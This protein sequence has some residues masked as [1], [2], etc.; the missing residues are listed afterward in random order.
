MGRGSR[1]G[2]GTRTSRGAAAAQGRR[3]APPAPAATTIAA[4]EAT[5]HPAPHAEATSS[6]RPAATTTPARPAAPTV[7]TA[8]ARAATPAATTTPARAAETAQAPRTEGAATPRG[9]GLAW[10]T[11]AAVALFWCA[12]ALPYV[13]EGYERFRLVKP[14]AVAGVKAPW[15]AAP[16]VVPRDDLE[17][18]EVVDHGLRPPELRVPPPPTDL[19]PPAP[20]TSGAGPNADVL[21]A[22]LGL[23][24]GSIEDESGAMAHFYSALARTAA[25]EPGAVTRIVHFGDSPVTGDLITGGARRRLQTLYGD[26]GHGWVLPQ[27]PWEWYNHVG[28]ELDGAGWKMNSPLFGSARDGRCGLAG[29]AFR[30]ARGASTKIATPRGG[31]NGAVSDFVVH[32]LGRPGGGTLLASVDGAP[33]IEIGTAAASPAPATREIHVPDGP[34]SLSLSPKGDGEVALYGVALEREE[35][36]VVYDSIGA[37]GATAHFLSLL[38][39][40]DWQAELRLR[41]PDLVVLNYGT[42]ESG[43]VGLS[44]DKLRR[45]V[46]AL[47]ARV[48]AAAPNASVL[49]MAPMDRGARGEDGSLTT[50][51]TIPQIVEAER[52]AAKAAGAA[53]FDTYSAM[54]G[55]GTMARW[56]ERENRLVSGDLTHPTG[57]GADIVSR[58][59]VDALEAGRR[60][61]GAQGPIG[62]A[63]GLG[64]KA[65]AAPRRA[66]APPKPRGDADVAAAAETDAPKSVAAEAEKETP[67]S[68]AAEAP[69]GGAAETEKETPRSGAAEA[70]SG[71]AAEAEKGTPRPDEAAAPK[72]RKADRSAAQQ[73]GAPRHAGAERRQ[74]RVRPAPQQPGVGGLRGGD[75]K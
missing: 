34:H 13:V 16:L 15:P 55:S 51:A 49:V 23:A 24:A 71:G 43:Y 58:L 56:Y 11:I 5:T 12:A 17:S 48:R 61:S 46:E 29:V 22:A 52:A 39:A 20:G 28:V 19:R 21:V 14:N 66:A 25:R 74:R 7:L 8:P 45:D 57:M 65:N 30:A 73:G 32:Y 33:A 2:K 40:G 59:L 42:N 44:M 69:R 60:A 75:Q 37:N 63:D 4:A 1:A 36:G 70:P 53:F 62:V 27:R 38:D 6:V 68:G 35:P 3:A 26:A 67:R 9:R 31:P 10:K 18:I 54:G 50:M 64:A 47:I 72:V 41:R